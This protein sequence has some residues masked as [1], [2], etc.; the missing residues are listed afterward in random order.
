MASQLAAMA[1]VPGLTNCTG[2]A[3]A[4]AQPLANACKQSRMVTSTC[5][6][7]DKTKPLEEA[8]AKVRGPSYLTPHFG[9][10]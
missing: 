9:C 3:L 10:V 6:C 7:A 1:I 4:Q 2:R 5:C 8:G